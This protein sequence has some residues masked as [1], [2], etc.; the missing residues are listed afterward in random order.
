MTKSFIIL[1]F[2]YSSTLLER[3]NLKRI[4]GTDIYS[5]NYWEKLVVSSPS[6]VDINSELHGSHFFV[7][8]LFE[9][10]Y[11]FLLLFCSLFAFWFFVFANSAC[12]FFALNFAE[13]F[14]RRWS[15][16]NCA[17][18]VWHF[19]LNQGD[20]HWAFIMFDVAWWRCFSISFSREPLGRSTMRSELWEI[21]PAG[22]EN[23]CQTN[24]LVTKRA[25]VNILQNEIVLIF[26]Y[27]NL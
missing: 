8:E 26:K 23:W 2:V 25:W 20:T 9:I 27:Y 14:R 13:S 15:L 17:C 21:F 12:Q 3:E 18:S 7:E 24:N 16:E 10:L 4:Y 6:L 19:V 22:D 11:V 1:A 5:K